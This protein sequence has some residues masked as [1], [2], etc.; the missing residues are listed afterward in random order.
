VSQADDKTE[1]VKSYFRRVDAGDFPAEYFTG[2]FE[3][4]V[5]KYGVGRGINAFLEMATVVQATRIHSRHHQ[6]QLSYMEAGNKVAVEGTTE[7]LG[8][9][10]VA[11]CGGKTSGGRFCSIFEFN[12]SNLI[13]RMYIYLDPDFAGADKERFLWKRS[14]FEW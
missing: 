10:N 9:D 6:E 11:W 7:G 2:D 3:F 13:R 8:R 1:I 12:E 14:R 4:F 5:P